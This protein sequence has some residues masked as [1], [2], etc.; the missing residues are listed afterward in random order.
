MKIYSWNVNSL[1]SCENNFLEFLNNYSPDIVGIQELRAHPDQL[2]FFLKFV[3]GY[4]VLFN[5]SGR[6]G[7]AGTALYYKDTLDVK[8]ITKD[9]NNDI[10]NTEG[11]AIKIV[12]D[13]ITILQFE[14]FYIFYIKFILMY[15]YFLAF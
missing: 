1:R 13:D 4:K 6:P 10:L 12:I 5:D 14:I 8:E 9:L 7:Y 15:Y 3:D 11:R 2:S